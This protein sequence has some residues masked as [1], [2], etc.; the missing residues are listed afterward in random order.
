MPNRVKQ[1]QKRLKRLKTELKRV[2]NRG[3]L[4]QKG[5]D[6]AKWGKLVQTRLNGAE[7]G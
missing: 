6:R 5:S 7:L 4:G 1:G 3:K 2:P